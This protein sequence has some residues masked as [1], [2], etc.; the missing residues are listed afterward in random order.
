MRVL[1][2]TNNFPT[3][4]LPIFGIFVKEQIASL[5]A[6]G[7]CNEVFFING[8]EFGK[9]AYLKSIAQIRSKLD[10]EQY[11]IIH[12]HHA[13]S[14]LCLVLSGKS[15]RNKVVVS[16]QNDPL[17]ELGK[18]IYG[19]IK[20]YATASIFKNN[21]PFISGANSHYI[22]NGVNIDFFKPLS[23]EIARKRLG[24]DSDTTY[25]LFVSSNFI[26]K[27]KRY[28]RFAETIK[29]LKEKYRHTNIQEIILTN[30]PREKI[31][32]YFNAVDAHVLTSDFEG[33]PNSVKESMACNTSVVSTDVGNVKELLDG[34]TGSYVANKKRAEELAELVDLALNRKENNGREILQ[35][36]KLDM[37]SVALEVKSLYDRL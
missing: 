35:K 25:L 37:N 15:K 16:F 31:P 5:E 2:I 34:V 28:D 1:H 32:L 18:P 7:I 17:H 24:L 29:I 14:A 33:S 22:P 30:T 8:R 12:C 20:R 19:F 21:S 23:R 4:R 13:L 36:K 26:R 11:D 27:Q 10:K 9:K 3:S 6:L